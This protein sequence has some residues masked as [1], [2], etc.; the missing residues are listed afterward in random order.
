MSEVIDI[1]AHLWAEDWLPKRWWESL[2]DVI[3]R[4]NETHGTEIDRST[5]RERYLP[6]Y[7]DPE[8]EHLLERMEE[9]GID[10]Q[11]VFPIDWGLHLGEPDTSIETVNRHFADLGAAHD[12]LITFATIDPRR[13]G[14]VE[15]IDRA[16]GEWG[17]SGL[18]LHPTAGFHLH[19]EETYR[20][21]EV[22]DDY[23]VPVL[24]DSGPISAPLYSKYSHPIH[25]DE[26][27]VDFPD[28]DVVVAHMALGW[29]RDL[30]AIA[31]AKINT[32][33]HVDVSA[34][35]DRAPEHPDEF[36]TA[37]RGFVDALG[38]TRVH[39]GTDDPAFDPVFPKDDWI[40]LVAGLADR[41][42]DPTFTQAEVDTILGAG[43][44][45][46]LPE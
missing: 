22:A 30:L 17:M 36:A 45:K 4:E 2:V 25:V 1:H 11:V 32:G 23:D 18:K 10:K 24:T 21:L 20:L 28:L 46:L 5:V 44:A 42:V 16:L 35:Q 31:D 43:A 9:A 14:A 27:L 33:L 6:T 26:V 41:T 13:D 19:D 29:W 38:A 7:W 39:F 15:F 37:V 40:E 8:A 34:W 3:V 12:E